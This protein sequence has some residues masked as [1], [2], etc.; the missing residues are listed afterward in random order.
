VALARAFLR[1]AQILVLDEPT[2]ALDAKAE[3]A[4]FRNFRELAAGRTAILIS[5]RFS[6]IRMADRIFVLQ[7]GKVTEA[8]THDEL[9]DGGGAYAHLYETQAHAYR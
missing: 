3:V 6:T 2:S 5:H 1:G 9:M 7:D 8:G 4:V